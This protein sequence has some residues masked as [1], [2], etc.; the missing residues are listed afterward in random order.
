MSGTN[1][2]ACSAHK[3]RG[4]L[5][6]TPI[7]LSALLGNIIACAELDIRLFEVVFYPA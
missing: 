2:V 4:G 3:P 6:S 5:Q 7:A 1:L